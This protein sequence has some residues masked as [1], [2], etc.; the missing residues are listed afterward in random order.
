MAARV[1]PRPASPLVD[2]VLRDLHRHPPGELRDVTG[3]AEV[4]N[5]DP[6]TR[7]PLAVAFFPDYNVEDAARILPAADRS[8]QLSAA[9]MEACG[10]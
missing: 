1:A 5:A 7:G 4:V 8:E 9:G 6:A 10:A 2:D 3:G